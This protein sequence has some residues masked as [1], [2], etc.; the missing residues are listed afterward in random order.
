MDTNMV[1]D[2]DDGDGYEKTITVK[3]D[4]SEVVILQ[5]DD[6]MT[7]GSDSEDNEPD[8]EDEQ[9]DVSEKD[10]EPEEDGSDD[11]DDEEDNEDD[12]DAES[13]KTSKKSNLDSNKRKLIRRV[14]EYKKQNKDYEDNLRR[15]QEE[16]DNLK[17]TQFETA[18]IALKN[19]EEKVSV[20]LSSLKDQKVAAR[21]NDDIDKEM[22]IDLEITKL[23]SEK[24]EIERIQQQRLQYKDEYKKPAEEDKSKKQSNKQ[25]EYEYTDEQE[26]WLDANPWFDQRTKNFDQEAFNSVS[27]YSNYLADKWNRNGRGEEVGSQEFLEKITKY[28]KKEFSD[29]Y[30]SNEK[31]LPLKK[32]QSFNP[33]PKVSQKTKPKLTETDKLGMKLMG[34]TEKE[35]LK[36]R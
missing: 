11:D 26:E 24:I 27:L 18:E 6:A 8:Q 30:R 16:N 17:R 36:Y 2:S 7:K 20:R 4:S 31:K 28:A 9:E 23:M 19:A 34:M 22:D 14:H 33:P 3:D 21:Q 10:G 5:D 29:Y 32:K 25:E 15:L 12:D 1:T 35:W 13:D